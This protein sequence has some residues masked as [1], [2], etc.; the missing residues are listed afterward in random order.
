MGNSRTAEELLRDNIA[1]LGEELGN[2]YHH[3]WQ[4]LA[5]L[6]SK[7]NEY[8]ELFGTKES[9]LELINSAS[10]RFFKI[11]QDSLWEDVILHIARMTDPPKSVGK[12]NLT[13]K[14]LPQLVND[15]DLKEELQTL[16]E[17]S[18]KKTEFCRDWRNRRIAHKDLA[19]VIEER[20]KP[21][22][23]ATRAKV[24]EA[25]SSLVLILNTI[26]RHYMD[27][28]TKFDMGFS[29]VGGAVS[30]LYVID[31]GL[32]AQK[33]RE[34]RLRSGNFDKSDFQARDL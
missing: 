20:I 30:L 9:R 11:V 21:L 34:V 7:W 29:N 23:P 27:S 25:L 2:V 28:E 12:K 18:V 8:V 14:A 10:P 22:K 26:S 3:L 6:Y 17:T 5:W 13:V 24:K 31:D 4:E 15:R 32:K 33:E 16:I 1:V 19:L